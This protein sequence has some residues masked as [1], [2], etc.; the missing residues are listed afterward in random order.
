MEQ[1]FG[2]IVIIIMAKAEG[3]GRKL[4]RNVAIESGRS[5][6]MESV[7]FHSDEFPLCYK[8]ESWKHFQ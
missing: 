7:V 2:G 1:S 8:R 5:Q 6:I 3:V 4:V